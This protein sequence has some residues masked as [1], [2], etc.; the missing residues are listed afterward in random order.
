MKRSL[1]VITALAVVGLVLGGYSL[2]GHS[3]TAKAAGPITITMAS[4]PGAGNS[5]VSGSVTIMDLGGAGSPVI[6][7][8]NV[9]GLLPFEANFPTVFYFTNSDCLQNPDGSGLAGIGIYD[10]GYPDQNAFLIEGEGLAGVTGSGGNLQLGD[11]GW[12]SPHCRNRHRHE[13]RLHR[14]SGRHQERWRLHAARLPGLRERRREWTG[15]LQ[16]PGASPAPG[17]WRRD[18]LQFRPGAAP[19][20][21]RGG[22]R[23]RPVT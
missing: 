10:A 14:W 1:I 11:P 15:Q 3:G 17:L 9:N 5:G 21:A 16:H 6:G 7:Q 12:R 2:L 18:R 8:E 23:P 20:T 4:I 13:G 19:S 22:F